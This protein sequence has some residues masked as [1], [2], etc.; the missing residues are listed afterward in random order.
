MV[1]IPFFSAELLFA[2]LWLL[3][4]IL[5]WVRQKEIHWKREALL[6]LMY[7]NLAVVLRFTFF[8][9]GSGTARR[10]KANTR[11]AGSFRPC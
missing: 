7:V 5:V 6:L 11:R 4:R 3:S 1:E 9:T 2:A 10:S 8:S